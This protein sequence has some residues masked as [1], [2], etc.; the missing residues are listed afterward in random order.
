M[1]RG[2]Q[3]YILVPTA[4]KAGDYGYF[5]RW[6]YPLSTDNKRYCKRI[7]MLPLNL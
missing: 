6:H 1:L 5:V 7:G 4:T 3:T 2:S